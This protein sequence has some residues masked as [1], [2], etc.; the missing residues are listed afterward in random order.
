MKKIKYQI[1]V[2][3]VLFFHLFSS[4]H[5]ATHIHH[6]MLTSHDDCKVCIVVKNLHS[7][8]TPSTFVF[9]PI[10]YRPLL[11]A[12]ISPKTHTYV[13]SKYIYSHAPPLFS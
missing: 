2:L 5:A 8:D 1:I 7:A 13:H 4:Y 3:F 9:E 6:D 10:C 11:T 12:S